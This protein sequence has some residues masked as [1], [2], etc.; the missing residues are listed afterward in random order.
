MSSTDRR[1]LAIAMAEK[2]V[3]AAFD[4]PVRVV[5]DNHEVAEWA[6]SI[7]AEPL[8]VDRTGLSASV[9]AAVQ[10]AAAEGFGRVIIAHADLPFA[11]DITVVDGLGLA[12]APDRR[13]D[14]S[15]VMSVP[16]DVGFRFAY[17]PGSFAAHLAEAKRLGL[18]IDII[19]APDLA[20]DIDDPGD[21]PDDWRDMLHVGSPHERADHRAS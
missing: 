21:L 13:R 6:R 7:G 11:E 17:G 2:V 1:R 3:A 18:E 9:G 15:N 20:W 16:T 12:L 19:E 10:I 8:A 14:G 5:T 4:L